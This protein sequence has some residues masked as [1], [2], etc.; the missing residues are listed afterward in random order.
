MTVIAVKIVD[1]VGRK[2]MLF[3]GV[4]GMVTSLLVLGVSLSALPTPHHPGDP[5]AIITL[6]CLATFIAAFAATWGPVV[7]V[8]LPEV[9]PLSVRGTAMGVAVFGNWA[10]NFAVSQTFP[11]L[12]KAL[13]PGT[14]FLGYAAL[15]L[16]AGVFVKALVTET[17]GRSLEEIEADLHRRAGRRG[18]RE[19]VPRHAAA[20][21]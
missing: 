10:A 17:K 6:V 9:L 20:S 15:G 21:R 4:A 5:A 18:R 8:M 16:L 1:R 12:L 19:Q 2:P 14:V 11:P 13:G 7:W 3:A